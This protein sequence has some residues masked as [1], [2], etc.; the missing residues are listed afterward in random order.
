MLTCTVSM[1]ETAI[2]II[3]TCLPALRTMILGKNSTKGT[4][5]YGKHYELSS[6]RRKTA[7]N[8]LTANPNHGRTQNT[9]ISQNRANGS[10]DS[11]FSDG[12]PAGLG[13]IQT[14]NKITVN[15]QIE[16]MF[17][18]SRN[19]SAKSNKKLPF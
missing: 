13:D 3:A 15:T 7:E 10:E 19:N 1:V 14:T 16:T 12:Q 11:L 2:A 18:D 4:N 5:S 6:A 17:E 8:R 9:Q